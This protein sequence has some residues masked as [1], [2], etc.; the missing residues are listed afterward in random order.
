VGE[1]AAKHWAVPLQIVRYVQTVD[2]NVRNSL[3]PDLYLLQIVKYVQ[4]EDENAKNSPPPGAVEGCLKTRRTLLT[5]FA[6][7]RRRC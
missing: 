7:D 6:M 2:E 4:T 3:P 1:N 5:F